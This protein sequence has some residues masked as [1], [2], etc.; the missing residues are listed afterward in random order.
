MVRILR[1][2]PAEQSQVLK[3]L[4]ELIKWDGDEKAH[5]GV[6]S[7]VAMWE[8]CIFNLRVYTGLDKLVCRLIAFREIS[9]FPV[10]ALRPQGKTDNDL[11]E[12]LKLEVVSHPYSIEG[13][14]EIR[15]G[16]LLSALAFYS[17]LLVSGFETFQV[18]Y[19]LAD[20]RS[21]FRLTI[22]RNISAS[23][24]NDSS[25]FQNESCIVLIGLI[26]INRL[27]PGIR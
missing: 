26:R 24:G 14:E 7:I 21:V 15:N 20:S 17:K 13:R 4:R 22:F 27:I 12:E 1:Q 6:V 25:L 5:T 11:L 2:G 19:V 23:F 3:V 10:A 9:P 18:I 16:A 8:R